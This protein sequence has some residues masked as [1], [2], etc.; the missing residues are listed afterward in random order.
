MC[1]VRHGSIDGV[2]Y[3]RHTTRV[4]VCARGVELYEEMQ[5]V[6][7]VV[8]RPVRNRGNFYVHGVR[9]GGGHF[10]R[11]VRIGRGDDLFVM[12]VGLHHS[13]PIESTRRDS[14]SADGWNGDDAGIQIH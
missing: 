9:V 6:V 2:R 5:L 4:N 3:T 8:L 13:L 10:L 14:I 1:R 7:V 12:D 11:T